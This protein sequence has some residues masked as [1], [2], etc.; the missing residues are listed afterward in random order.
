MIVKLLHCYNGML[1]YTSRHVACY[2]V[3]LLQCYTQY[4]LA[5]MQPVTLLHCYN[6]TLVYTSRHAACYTVTLL[7]CYTSVY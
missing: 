4:I 1:V 7:Q 6:A 3:T 2:S 5:G